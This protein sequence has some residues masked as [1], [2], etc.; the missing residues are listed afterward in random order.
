MS[1][2]DY[3]IHCLKTGI[4]RIDRPGRVFGMGVYWTFKPNPKYGPGILVSED[5][6]SVMGA[7][8]L[9][10][11]WIDTQREQWFAAY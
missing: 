5:T 2:A 9:S 3:L 6:G 10:D 8:E 7:A 4:L 11:R 1:I